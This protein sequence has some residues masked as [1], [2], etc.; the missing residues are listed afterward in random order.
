MSLYHQ[1]A[2]IQAPVEEIWE[3]VG[4]VN[5][6]A[7]WWPRVVEVECE[8]LEEGCSYRLVTKGPFGT[9]E[10][11]MQVEKLQGCRE[12]LIRCLNTGTY[13]RWVMMEA[14]GGTF[15]DAEF[16]IAPL[17]VG[18]RVFDVLAGK[19]FFRRWVQQSLEA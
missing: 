16:G 2:Q 15:V 7:E 14:Q 4:D 1:Q 17:T 3:L 9:E 19:R 6:H 8:G 5:R 11:P 12:I 18:T 10:H 13:C